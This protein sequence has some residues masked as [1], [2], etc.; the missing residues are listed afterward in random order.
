MCVGNPLEGNRNPLDDA[1]AQ[2]K[3]V[4][5]ELRPQKTGFKVGIKWALNHID[6]MWI[7][8]SCILITGCNSQQMLQDNIN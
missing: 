1:V 4:E 6:Y 2:I 7:I 8:L 3:E 5:C